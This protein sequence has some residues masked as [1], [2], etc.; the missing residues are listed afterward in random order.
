MLGLSAL[1]LELMLTKAGKIGEQ[2][3]AQFHWPLQ[4]MGTGF[5]LERRYALAEAGRLAGGKDDSC[6]R[7]SIA[8]FIPPCEAVWGTTFLAEVFTALDG[9]I[10]SRKDLLKTMIAALREAPGLPRDP[11]FYLKPHIDR[12]A[13][14]FGIGRMKKLAIRAALKFA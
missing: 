6:L 1:A 7:K 11:W 9:R 5:G 8:A 13:K 12:Y 2:Q 3:Y 14:V 10:K 4:A